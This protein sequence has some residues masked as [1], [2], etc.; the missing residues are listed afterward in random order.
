MQ[1]D[2]T[3]LA[4]IGCIHIVSQNGTNNI[5]QM[6]STSG[7]CLALV[8]GLTINE[9]Y[10]WLNAA[11]GGAQLMQNRTNT[12]G[13]VIVDVEDAQAIAVNIAENLQY[14]DDCSRTFWEPILNRLNASIR[15]PE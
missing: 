14:D 1:E 12:V 10:L 2:G 8:V 5:Y 15:N 6:A 9:V 11:I 7:G 4:Q 3:Y 13:T